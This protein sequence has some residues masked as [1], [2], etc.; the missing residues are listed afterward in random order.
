VLRPQG[1]ACDVGATE[2]APPSA[3]TGPATGVAQT[4]ATLT[5]TASNPAVSAGQAVFQYGLSIAYGP[6][7]VAGS[8]AAA[9]ASAPVSATPSG[10]LPN[11]VYH[12]RLVFTTSDGQAFGSD[13]T[14]ATPPAPAPPPPPP[15][16]K[17]PVVNP[18]LSLRVIRFHIQHLVL[19]SL[20]VSVNGHRVRHPIVRLTGRQR[21]PTLIL[22][23]RGQPRGAYRIHLT[24]RQRTRH[25]GT[26]RFSQTR[27]F[28]TCRPGPRV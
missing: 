27:L 12:Y 8:V 22:S 6:S 23:L 13:Q 3:T 26:R 18:C 10:L 4:S 17:K 25:H 20:Q 28:H 7:I 19:G 16:K 1:S 5:G 21:I 24:G 11:T 15:P 9:S 2:L 14:F